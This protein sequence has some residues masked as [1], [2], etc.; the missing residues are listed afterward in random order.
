[1]CEHMDD[2]TLLGH[3]SALLTEARDLANQATPDQTTKKALQDYVTNVDL[4]V[5]VFLLERLSA[6]T[7]HAPV[8]SEER[9]V[10]FN[11]TVEAYWIVDPID[12]TLNLMTGLPFVG[13][14]VAYVDKDGPRVAAVMSLRDGVLFSA[15]RGQGAWRNEVRLDL[16]QTLPTELIVLSTGLM[17]RLTADAP[18]A[19]QALRKVGKI[20]NLGSQALHLCYVA[21]GTFSGVASVEAKVWDEAAGGLIVREA[22]GIW[23]SKAD[24]ANWSSPSE[25]MGIAKQN[26]LSCHPATL[27]ALTDALN[28]LFG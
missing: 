3:L 10:D 5:D 28:P 9:A 11:H 7:P 12:G 15:I 17:D 27:N 26:S 1:M 6:L 25:M 4:A 19:Y 23:A 22:G 21:A 16:P 14:S 20:R 24:S 13:I 2:K 8:L 18:A